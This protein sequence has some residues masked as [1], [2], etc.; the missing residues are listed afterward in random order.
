RR[1]SDPY[2]GLTKQ[3]CKRLCL[4]LWGARQVGLGIFNQFLDANSVGFAVAVAG[5]CVASPGGLDEN[6]GPNHAGADVD[7]SNFGD[8]DGHLIAT[9]PRPFVAG[10]RFVADLD[11]GRE[12]KVA[13]GPA[14]G[15]KHFG[16]HEQNVTERE[17]ESKSR[18]LTYLAKWQETLCA[19]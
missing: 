9:E 14:T 13:L 10:D 17:R 12:E 15:L 2:A 7:G 18:I 19:E 5:D 1:E 4:G 8:A 16:W 3:L 11:P 6:L